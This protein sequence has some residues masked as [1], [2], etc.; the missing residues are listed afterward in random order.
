[1][2]S[3]VPEI[4]IVSDIFCFT[5]PR[6]HNTPHTAKNNPIKATVLPKGVCQLT[7]IITLNYC[8]SKSQ[9]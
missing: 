7:L 3:M 2:T 8:L 4:N 6:S 9:E 5:R 1:M